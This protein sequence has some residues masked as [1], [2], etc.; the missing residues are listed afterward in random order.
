MRK[1]KREILY[2]FLVVIMTVL[3][4]FGSFSAEKYARIALDSEIK[5]SHESGFYDAPI[6]VEL[7]V[8][9]NYYITYTLDGRAPNAAS[10]RYETPILIDDASNNANVWSEM[11]ETSLLY[12]EGNRYAAPKDKVD[13]CT[14]LRTAAFDYSGNQVSSAVREYFIGMKDKPGY[15]DIYNLCVVTDPEN[16]FSEEKG[17]YHVGQYLQ[18]KIDSCKIYKM[19]KA[20]TGWGGEDLKAN[21]FSSGIASERPGTIELFDS[22][23]QLLTRED[24]G[25]RVRGGLSRSDV[26]K[27]LGFYAREKYSGENRFAYDVFGDGYGQKDFLAHS[28]G[29]D[30]DVKIID[31]VIYRVLS[32]GENTFSVT[33]MV[34][35]NLFLEGEYWGPMFL[36][37]DINASTISEEFGVKEDNVL[38][39][40]SGNVK[41]SDDFIDLQEKELEEWEEIQDFIRNNDMSVQE[42]YD[43]VCS[44]ID[45]KDF[46]EYAATEVYIGNA[47]W[48]SDNNYAC[49]RTMKL[50]KD[51][52]YSDG[53]WRFCLFDVNWSFESDD[54][55]WGE[56]YSDWDFYQMIKCLGQNEEFESLFRNKISDLEVM[57][58]P[59]RVKDIISD[60]SN[61]MEEPIRCNFKRF[62]IDEDAD[63]A[64]SSKKN[65]IMTF[66]E[67]RPDTI[68]TMYSYFFD[69]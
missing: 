27:P 63:A 14:I 68:E 1:N 53:K 25:I 46:A 54:V 47:D 55:I 67:E 19:Y 58:A 50:E 43:Y 32:E 30:C 44:K 37:K 6:E 4:I 26:Q 49:W 56:T 62:S 5:Y 13:K 45:I 64:I 61:I 60:W 31:Y 10:M 7:S 35:C 24:C 57:F 16:L 9:S 59:D 48:H 3:A 38:L 41:I 40:K 23:G 21:W 52:P 22:H 11:R 66:C 17:I 42:N 34:P 28:L 18:G 12:F 69:R 51:N 20:G 39:I 8:G 33:P 36:I 2:V 29:N 65:Q 15:K